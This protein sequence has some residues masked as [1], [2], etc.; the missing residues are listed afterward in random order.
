MKKIFMIYIP[1]MIIL[2]SGYFVFGDSKR[3]TPGQNQTG[4]LSEELR[5][6]YQETVD[7]KGLQLSNM[8]PKSANKKD[9]SSEQETPLDAPVQERGNIHGIVFDVTSDYSD[10]RFNTLKCAGLKEEREKA[11]VR[12]LYGSKV[13]RTLTNG[14][15]EYSFSDLPIQK[16]LL[17]AHV[18]QDS[19]GGTLVPAQVNLAAW[20]EWDSYQK[21]DLKV[22]VKYRPDLVTV[23]GR[24]T[25]MKG[26]PVASARV[27]ATAYRSQVHAHTKPRYS[28][29]VSNVTDINGYY[30]LQGLVPG[31]LAQAAIGCTGRYNYTIR[32]EAAGL[33]TAEMNV[34]IE[35][36]SLIAPARRLAGIIV[37]LKKRFPE[38]FGNPD[39]KRKRPAMSIICIGN[40][41]EGVDFTLDPVSVISGQVVDAQGRSMPG[42]KLNLRCGKDNFNEPFAVRFIYPRH[43]QTNESGNFSFTPIPSGAYQITAYSDTGYFC[44]QNVATLAPGVSRTNLRLKFIPPPPGSIEGI[45]VDAVSEMPLPNFT[46]KI[47]DV[48]ES[49]GFPPRIGDLHKDIARPGLF[50]VKNIASGKAELELTVPGYSR[51]KVTVKVECGKTAKVRVRLKKLPKDAD[52]VKSNIRVKVTQNEAPVH[53]TSYL[54]AYSLE[55]N[56]QTYTK[57]VPDL[58]GWYTVRDVNAERYVIRASVISSS[59]NFR[60]FIF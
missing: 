15:G 55:S 35:P 3:D 56:S 50:V 24:I 23:K 48:R 39:L 25:D 29:M 32:V 19:A 45:V 13:R 2:V 18:G 11:W 54:Q 9:L 7:H 21:L 33:V 38:E 36:E 46:A 52:S 6:E 47:L 37:D 60:S 4:K 41:L 49:Q 34:P 10:K 44:F 57:N 53:P 40:K 20:P 12:F 58:E 31:H 16:Y 51:A 28:H 26:Q 27:I 1:L 42:I 14:K 22:D 8:L 5:S 17:T 30:E 59:A 43:C